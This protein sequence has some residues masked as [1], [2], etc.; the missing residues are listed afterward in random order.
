MIGVPVS[1][2]YGRTVLTCFRY[3]HT[4]ISG[5][6]IL[7]V[8]VIFKYAHTALPCFKYEHGFNYKVYV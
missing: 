1:F 6:Y 4:S 3:E 2:K 5:F 7:C 8:R